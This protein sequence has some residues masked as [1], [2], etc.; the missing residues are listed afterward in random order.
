MN[1]TLIESAPAKTAGCADA[2]PAAA[3]TRAV[4]SRMANVALT[5]QV[6]FAYACATA[7]GEQ[8]G[9]TAD[10]IE[11]SWPDTPLRSMVVATYRAQVEQTR[12]VARVI[13]RSARARCGL[14][15]ARVAA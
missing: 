3:S 5:A 7:A 12:A 10:Y 15:F 14:A 6:Q 8:A 2:Q 1:V 4:A 11:E 9:R 13:L